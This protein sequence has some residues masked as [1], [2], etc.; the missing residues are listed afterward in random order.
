MEIGRGRQHMCPLQGC[1]VCVYVT[2]IWCCCEWVLS[3]TL[4]TGPGMWAQTCTA[5]PTSLIDLQLNVWTVFSCHDSAVIHIISMSNRGVDSLVNV[6][7]VVCGVW[8]VV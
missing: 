3:P 7:C 8:C 1:P 6:W 2:P 4:C 5:Q